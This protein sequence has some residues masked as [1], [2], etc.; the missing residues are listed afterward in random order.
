M[1]TDSAGGPYPHR[2]SDDDPKRN[3]DE[4]A[5][6]YAPFARHLAKIVV[7][8]EA[9]NGYVIGLHGT[10]GSGKS[11]AVNFVRTYVAE[12]QVSVAASDK[13]ELLEFKPWMVA[14]HQDLFSSFF[15]VLSEALAPETEARKKASKKRFSGAKA[16]S[17]TLLD[18]TAAVGIATVN[19]VGLAAGGVAMVA[20]GALSL[21]AG[22]WLEE[23]SLQAAYENLRELLKKEK[24]R[25]LVVIDDIDRLEPD[26]IR[27]IVQMAKTIGRLPSMVYLLVYDRRIVW[28]ALDEHRPDIEGQPRFAEKIVQQEIDLPRPPQSKLLSALEKEIGFLIATTPN[29]M[30]WHRIISSGLRRWIRLP[31][32]VLRLANA[33]KFSWPALE[34]EIDPQDLLAIE[35]MRLFDPIAFEWIRNNRSFLF[36][37]D[38]RLAL[39]EGKAV[40]EELRKILPQG[41]CDQ[42]VELMA[43]LFPARAKAI[44]GDERRAMGGEAHYAV[45][46]RRGIGCEA[47]YDA[48]FGFYPPETT[49]PK[50]TI[51]T[52]FRNLDEQDALNEIF[53]CELAKSDPVVIGEFFKEIQ[54]RL[55][56]FGAPQPTT[57]LLSALVSVADGALQFDDIGM[58]LLGGPRVQFRFLLEE[59]LKAWG[60]DVSSDRLPSALSSSASA[61]LCSDIYV[62]RAQELGVIPSNDRD[63]PPLISN[64]AL[65]AIGKQTLRL[66]RMQAKGS[67]LYEA[68]YYFSILDAWHHLAGVSAPKA[69]VREGVM[70]SGVV[71]A[72]MTKGMLSYSMDG[73]KRQYSLRSVPTQPYFQA[74]VLRSA[75]ELHGDDNSLSDD[76][77]ARIFALKDGLDYFASRASPAPDELK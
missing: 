6:G 54:Y 2:F 68:P 28:S 18:A 58:S 13:L 67:T 42:I 27:S 22:K 72:R 47:G 77:R 40:G 63:Q 52:V 48:Y 7:G 4:D 11:T 14:G 49:V 23:P 46:A 30:R 59:M 8:L 55:L 25:F 71:L 21:A 20:K 12:L 69:W 37:H 34:N 35:G 1:A 65:N 38:L 74:R 62:A 57:E 66:I 53:E 41:P 43:A 15:K 17:D 39:D 50:T 73:A 24:R 61:L 32:D 51:D 9:P 19:P 3:P 56:G 26:E 29:S 76:E 60:L 36:G 75:C 33:V 44:F 45:V 31:R 16:A 10:W 70:T 64:E 5:Y